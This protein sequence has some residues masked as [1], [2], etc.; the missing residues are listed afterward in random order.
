MD[1]SRK[2]RLVAGAHL[3]KD[4]PRHTTYSSVVSR[5]TV[6][7]CFMIATMNNLNVLAGDVGNAYLNAKPRGKCH[8]ILNDE[9]IFGPG[10]VGKTALIIRALYGM[11]RSG[12]AWRDAISSTLH[13]NMGF[14]QCL[15]DND[16]W[17]KEDYCDDSGRYY[18]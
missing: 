9:W 12:A 6:L 1:L 15:A 10:A 7:L 2:A 11:K 17:F 13:Y 18:T 16:L 3:N 14:T 8:V 4:V 5:K